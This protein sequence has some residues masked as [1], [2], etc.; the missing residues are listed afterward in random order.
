MMYGLCT[1]VWCLP[2]AEILKPNKLSKSRVG[3]HIESILFLE[4]TP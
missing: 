1:H 3:D 2:G 4:A